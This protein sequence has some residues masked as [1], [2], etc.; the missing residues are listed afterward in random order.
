MAIWDIYYGCILTSPFSLL[1]WYGGPSHLFHVFTVTK[2]F[3]LGSRCFCRLF[4]RCYL[5]PLSTVIWFYEAYLQTAFHYLEYIT[6]C[7]QKLFKKV[8]SSLIL[9]SAQ[10]LNVK[11]IF[12][13]ILEIF[14]AV[15]VIVKF[16][17]SAYSS[18]DV[19]ELMYENIQTSW[20]CKF[21][22]CLSFSLVHVP[23]TSLRDTLQ[24]W[25]IH[26]NHTLSWSTKGV[27][28][29]YNNITSAF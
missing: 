10:H 23:F 9:F 15:S 3:F 18:W 12:I 28:T 1:W 5:C 7:Y 27:N 17:Y 16:K 13:A 6:I 29:I 11:H 8:F 26:K 24:I 22:L 20:I 2:I 4:S 14:H 19:R 25:I 21:K